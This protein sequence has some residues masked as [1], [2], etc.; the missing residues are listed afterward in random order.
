[1]LRFIGLHAF[2]IVFFSIWG[3]PETGVTP[4]IN[5]K[6]SQSLNN[7][8]PS[9]DWVIKTVSGICPQV[10]KTRT[11]PG[12]Y[13]SQKNPLPT[14]EEYVNSGKILY[15]KQAKP[16]P[17]RMCHGIRGNG[18]GKLAVG[19]EPPPRNFTCFEMMKEIP[20]GQLF[21]IIKNGSRGTAMPAHK[22]TLSDRQI[23]QLIHYLRGFSKEG[24][25]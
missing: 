6:K 12:K 8:I 9:S 19:M 15:Q 17:C 25:F 16:T 24:R 7:K 2:L 13:Y 23:W 14:G 4:N 1:M 10:R 22:S 18:N 3:L 21:W 20:D 5:Q 11:A